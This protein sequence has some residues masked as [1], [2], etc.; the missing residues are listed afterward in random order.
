MRQHGVAQRG[1]EMIDVDHGLGEFAGTFLR[2]VVTD[3]E[4]P[5][6]VV[7]GEMLPVGSS[8]AG[9]GSVGAKACRQR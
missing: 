1:L 9:R 7:A 3:R 6:G 5:V 8:A 2:H 4:R